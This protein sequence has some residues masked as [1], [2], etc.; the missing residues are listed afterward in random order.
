MGRAV[1]RWRR[2]G[3]GID[4]LIRTV[5]CHLYARQRTSNV[6][7]G[8]RRQR[9]AGLFTGH[10]RK[11]DGMLLYARAANYISFVGHRW[12]LAGRISILRTLSKLFLADFV[13]GLRWQNE[14]IINLLM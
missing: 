13:A 7:A 8:N 12:Q 1:S 14:G 9:F 6:S 11:L 5:R 4:L 3:E 10:F 2:T